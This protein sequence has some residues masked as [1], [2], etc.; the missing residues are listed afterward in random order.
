MTNLRMILRTVGF[1]VGILFGILV[2]SLLTIGSDQDDRNSQLVLL[3]VTIGG[4][5]YIIGPHLNWTAMSRLRDRVVEASIR[6]IVAVSVGLAFG[7][8][9]AAPLAFIMSLLPDPAGTTAAVAVAAA[10]IGSAI[11]VATIRRDDL[12]DPWFKPKSAKGNGIGL[13]PLVIDTNIAIDG[14]IVDLLATGFLSNPLILPRFVLDEL[15]HI[16]DSDDPQRRARGRRGLEVLTS[17]RTD[18]ANRIEIYDNPVTSERE[19]DA[20]LMQVARDH[21]AHLLTND[22]NLSKVAEMHGLQVLNLNLLA[23]ALRPIVNPGERITLKLVQEGREAGQ[24]VGF[25]DD[26]TM[27]VVDGGKALVGSEAPVTVTRLLQTGAGR[28]VFATPIKVTA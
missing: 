22:F 26:G 24:G 9:V 25:L 3:A 6:D 8:L 19:V 15:Q 17:I 2:G 4:I 14:R 12:L 5:G 23:N 27:V 20:K 11:A 16:A 18:F 13:K 21:N 28:M 7:S 10:T 1:A